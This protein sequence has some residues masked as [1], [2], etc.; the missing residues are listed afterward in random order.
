MEEPAFIYGIFDEDTK[1]L[2]YIGRS[3]DLAQR[4]RTHKTTTL[5]DIKHYRMEILEQ[6][7]NEWRDGKES[8]WINYAI[9]IGCKLLN[10]SRVTPGETWRKNQVYFNKERSSIN[11]A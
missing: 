7:D 9:F 2:I 6:D 5:K 10:K 1:E 3:K 11:G 4:M 8:F